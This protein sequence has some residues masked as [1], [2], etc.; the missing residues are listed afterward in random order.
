MGSGQKKASISQWRRLL[1]HI[2]RSPL[3]PALKTLQRIRHA[4]ALAVR[5]RLAVSLPAEARLDA[6]AE[7]LR[8]DGYVQLDEIVDAARLADLDVAGRAKQQR[9][10][11]AARHQVSGHKDFWTRLLDEDMRDGALPTDNPFVRFALQPA[12]IGVLARAFGELPQLDSVLLT[13]SRPTGND[14]AYS[15]LWHRDHD[16]VHT[17][18]L[19]VYLS[20]V[21]DASDGPFTFLP[22]PVS[23]RFGFALHSHRADAAILERAREDEFKVMIAPRLTTFMVETSRCLHMGS[24]MH[25]GHERLLYTATF[26]A[27]AR[28]FPEPPSR[29]RLCGDE[30]EI[31]RC[32]LAPVNPP[33]VV[34]V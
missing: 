10:D 20:D 11:E 1:W 2:N 15:Q 32:V 13:L 23:D 14:L 31:T 29:F 4:R 30:D 28:L 17:V 9:V 5:K 22:G 12:V 8:R 19:F 21:R 16:D 27:A 24:R 26:I 3:A 33:K 6:L 7:D 34:V 18:K 25:P